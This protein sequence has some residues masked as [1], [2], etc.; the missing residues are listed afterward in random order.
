MTIHNLNRFFKPFLFTLLIIGVSATAYAQPSDAQVIKDMTGPGTIS[1]KLTPKNG[2]KQWNGDYGIWEYVRGVEAIREYKQKKGVTIK[3]V[4]DAVYQMYG[5][6]D[7]KYWK[8]RV[9]SN[10]Y[11]G[12][13]VPS[14]E[15]LMKIVQSDLPKFLSTY[16][17][18]RIIGD[19]KALYI[20]DDPKITWHTPNSLSFDV[21]AEY[22]AKTSDIHIEDIVQTYNVRLYRDAEDKPWHNFISSRGKQ[23]TANKKEYSREEI[24]SMKT[25]AFI[26]GEKKASATYGST[27]A[28]KFKNGKEMALALN[29]ELRNGSPESVEAFLIK[30]L[31]K[32]HFVNG[33]DVQ[34][35]GRG[36]QLINDIVAKAFNG[37]SKYSQ[38]FC[39]NPTIDEGRSS[40][41]R[42]YLQGIGKRATLQVA[43][44]ESAGG[45]VDGVKQPGELKITSLDV[46]LA[47]KDDDI[48]FFSSFSSPSKA[49]PND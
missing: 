44:E 3:I 48:A 7:Y 8:F 25:L 30:T 14:S 16:W 43:F 32:M 41:K 42:I 33:S 15:D 31:H 35:T 27:P 39:N 23:E 47:Q 4:G 28:L 18:N 49:C 2:H 19:V 5:A 36:A 24:Q 13:D 38:Q 9:L 40:K 26:D 1:V 22:R 10:E 21:I 11:I 20:A 45:Y 29:K 46:Y 6:T 12:M 37:R 34:L 17:Y